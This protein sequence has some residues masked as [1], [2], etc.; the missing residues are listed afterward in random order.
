MA[1]A[2]TRVVVPAAVVVV[3]SRCV[4]EVVAADAVSEPPVA[5]VVAVAAAVAEVNQTIAQSSG[6]SDAAQPPA[7]SESST[8]KGA[9]TL[10]IDR[11]RG[12]ARHTL[13]GAVCNSCSLA[14][15][16]SRKY[17]P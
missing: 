3:D 15:A 12:A 2:H 7:E 5:V 16:V 1:H 8:N 9:S 14:N 10:S 11:R 4:A 17:Q 6:F 13:S